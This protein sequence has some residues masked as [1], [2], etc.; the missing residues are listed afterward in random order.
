MFFVYTYTLILRHVRCLFWYYRCQTFT[1]D[2][3]VW[4]QGHSNFLML[5]QIGIEKSWSI[6]PFQILICLFFFETRLKSCRPCWIIHRKLPVPFKEKQNMDNILWH[7]IIHLSWWNVYFNV[8]INL[9]SLCDLVIIIKLKIKCIDTFFIEIIL[10]CLFQE[11]L[12]F[13]SNALS[14]FNW[15]QTIINPTWYCDVVNF[16]FKIRSNNKPKLCLCRILYGHSLGFWWEKR[17]KITN[18][19]DY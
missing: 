5:L 1:P 19:A 18:K 13:V 6:S 11:M 16:L 4:H 8:L 14:F 7:F 9:T 15:S 17:T 12:I 2:C 10:S 3:L